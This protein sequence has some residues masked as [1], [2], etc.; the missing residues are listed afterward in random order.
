MIISPIDLIKA[1]RKYGPIDVR[2]LPE[3]IESEQKQ[4]QN[5][6]KRYKVV[7]DNLDW[8]GVYSGDVIDYIAAASC[9]IKVNGSTLTA[10]TVLHVERVL[11]AHTDWIQEIKDYP[12][13]YTKE[14]MIDFAMFYYA[15]K[16]AYEWLDKNTFKE[17]LKTRKS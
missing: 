16:D 12:K 17:W 14:D 1:Y 3:L 11:A 2:L 8:L 15:K 6:M 9:P 13:E 5:T 7:T 4:T 10:M